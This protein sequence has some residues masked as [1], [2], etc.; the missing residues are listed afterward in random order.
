MTVFFEKKIQMLLLHPKAIDSTQRINKAS[1]TSQYSNIYFD[2]LNATEK[3]ERA[4]A[5]K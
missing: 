2:F 5:A 3:G 4:V 1:R